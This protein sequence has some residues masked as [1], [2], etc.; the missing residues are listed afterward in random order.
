MFDFAGTGKPM[1]FFTPDLAHYSTDLRGFYFDLLAEAPGPVVHDRDASARCDPRIAHD[2]RRSGCGGAL[3]R[4]AWRERFT[5]L[6]DG[7]AGERVVQR[8][9]DAGWL[10][11]R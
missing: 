10:S 7:R 1:V 2:G 9:L 6:D 3:A 11:A 8:M 4:D 5:P